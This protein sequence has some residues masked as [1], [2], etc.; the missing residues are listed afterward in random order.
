MSY[1][2]YD[3][4]DPYIEDDFDNDFDAMGYAENHGYSNEEY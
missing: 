3:M 4:F 2:D 1:A